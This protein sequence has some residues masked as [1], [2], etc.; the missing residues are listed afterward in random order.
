M[1]DAIGHSSFAG[2]LRDEAQHFV[3]N[4]FMALVGCAVL[5]ATSLI[6]PLS[7]LVVH[8]ISFPHALMTVLM[9]SATITIGQLLYRLRCQKPRYYGIG[10]IIVGIASAIIA[11]NSV[12]ALE[13]LPSR[14]G[15]I[16]LAELGALYIIVRGMDN[17]HKGL[18]ADEKTAWE[19]RFYSGQHP[20]DLSW[21]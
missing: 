8:W 5:W 14:S 13:W 15:A 1:S 12:L 10:E 19:A 11:A 9:A 17:Y 20:R 3:L 7:A 4:L 16:L 2:Q 18:A 6:N 21:L